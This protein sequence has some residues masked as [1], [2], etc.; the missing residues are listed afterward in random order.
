MLHGP[1][2][3][4]SSPIAFADANNLKV[5][6]DPSHKCMSRPCFCTLRAGIRSRSRAVHLEP[7]L[8][9]NPVSSTHLGLPLQMRTD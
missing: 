5:P 9:K 7:E 2:F 4:P 1:K 6:R 3:A 8:T